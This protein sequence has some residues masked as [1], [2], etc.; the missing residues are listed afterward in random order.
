MVRSVL[1]IIFQNK[2]S[3]TGPIPALRND[4]DKPAQGQIIVRHHSRWRRVPW[5]RSHGVIVRQVHNNELWKLAVPFELP[6]LAL[7]LVYACL[8]GYI[9]DLVLVARIKMI[10]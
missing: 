8:I 7:E 5:L 3:R 1:S 2:D 9:S 6:E 4:F 10:L